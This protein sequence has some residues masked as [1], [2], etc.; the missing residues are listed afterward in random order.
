[1]NS[2]RLAASFWALFVIGRL[3]AAHDIITTNLTFTRDISRIFA[4]HCVG[5]HGSGSSIPLTTY[6][7]ARPWAVAIKEQVLA[8]AMP[9]WGA[10]KG[11]G[12]LKP[13]ESLSQEDILTIAAWVI[14]GAPQ[15]DI[16]LL[17]AGLPAAK[18]DVKPV[19]RDALI[20]ETRARLAKPIRA[21][22]IR[23]IADRKIVSARLT[24]RLPDGR[25]EPLIWLFDFGPSESRSF[26]F[27]QAL[28]LPVGTLVE[29]SSPVRF[30]LQTAPSGHQTLR[31]P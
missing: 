7:Q 16:R 13:D 24:A 4:R 12:N 15:G 9:P 22:G 29:S 27:R 30:A 19:L 20:V 8:R 25:I 10:L 18:P 11:F 26:S 14:G 23:P 1:M 3:C 6:A 21:S 5:C 17:P 28:E 31:A 2:V